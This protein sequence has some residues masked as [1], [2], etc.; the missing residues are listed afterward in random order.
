MNI[1]DM[2]PG[3]ISK[4]E[5]LR[6]KIQKRTSINN[7]KAEK[8][9]FKDKRLIEGA[10]HANNEFYKSL[11]IANN[12][13]ATRLNRR[14]MFKNAPLEEPYEPVIETRVVSKALAPE[15]DLPSLKQSFKSSIGRN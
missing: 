5:Y 2:L 15:F 9:G 10:F 13:K 8:T 7:L 12:S 14:Q 4:K 1:Q 6:N 11:S 3:A